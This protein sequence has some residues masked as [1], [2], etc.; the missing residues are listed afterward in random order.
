[1]YS[2]HKICVQCFNDFNLWFKGKNTAFRFGIRMILKKLRNHPDDY[3]FCSCHI[4]GYN[5]KNQKLIFY[6]EN[7]TSAIHS[8]PHASDVPVPLSLTE[9]PVISS[10]SSYSGNPDFLDSDTEYKLSASVSPQSFSKIELNNLARDSGL[11]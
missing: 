1:M 5:H 4:G 10:E 3:Y 2:T 8:I 11:F 9:S 7:I 6:P